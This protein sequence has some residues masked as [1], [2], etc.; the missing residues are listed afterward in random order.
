MDANQVDDRR[1]GIEAIPQKGGL[2]QMDQAGPADAKAI[3]LRKRRCRW[4]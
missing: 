2:F 4:L 1:R 3:I